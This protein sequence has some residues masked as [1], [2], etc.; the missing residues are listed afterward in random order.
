MSRQLSTDV[1]AGQDLVLALSRGHPSKIVELAHGLLRRTFTLRELA[2]LLPQVEEQHNADASER[3]RAAL[4]R[5]LRLR[6]AN[7]AGPEEDDVV[8][9]YRR[10]DDVYQRMV[11][12]L[13]PAVDTLLAWERQ[14]R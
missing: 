11:R 14:Y 3:W 12:E 2:R 1:L 10:S 4:A 6:S 13:A 9:P 5:A 8:D 7:P